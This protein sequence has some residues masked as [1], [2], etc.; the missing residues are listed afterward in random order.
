MLNRLAQRR[1]SLNPTNF[2]SCSFEH[3]R[4]RCK[5][6]V[7][8][9]PS[10]ADTLDMDSTKLSKKAQQALAI[11]KAGGTSVENA[12]D[13][14]N[15]ARRNAS[16]HDFLEA[17]KDALFQVGRDSDAEMLEQYE[18]VQTWPEIQGLLPG[19]VCAEISKYLVGYPGVE[20]A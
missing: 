13:I 7:D 1:P 20:A 10:S 11:L 4:N 14:Q 2:V 18:W 19:W 5:I 8:S 3:L 16:P 9:R 17:V 15:R 6:V 12:I